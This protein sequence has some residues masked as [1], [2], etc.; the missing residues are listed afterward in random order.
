MKTE[1]EPGMMLMRQRKILPRGFRER[2]RPTNTLIFGLLASKTV[3][4]KISV[5]LSQFVVLYYGSSR[6]LM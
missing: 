2:N 3:R 1:S 5:V 4:E 6:K